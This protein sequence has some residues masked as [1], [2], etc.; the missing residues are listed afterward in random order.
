MINMQNNTATNNTQ[1]STGSEADAA[2][3][4]S[5]TSSIGARLAGASQSAQNFVL[6]RQPEEPQGWLRIFNFLPNDHSYT[7]AIIS[8]ATAALF[9]FFTFVFLMMIVASPGKF[10]LLF[11]ITMICLL[12]GFAF[13][14]GPR[15]YVK[16]LFVSKNLYASI[17]LL[18]SIILALYFSLVQGSY[19]FSLIFCLVELNAVLFFFFNTGV[20][21][22]QLKWFCATLFGAAKSQMGSGGGG[23][24]T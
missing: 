19:I 11:T 24:S 17:A 18:S 23:G 6:G 21:L 1:Q 9:G 4:M 15:T 20:T 5:F 3:P 14:K 7:Y 2:K 16:S 10:V 12:T 8:F 22:T 13:L